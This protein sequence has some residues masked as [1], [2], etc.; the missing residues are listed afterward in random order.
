MDT[1]TKRIFCPKCESFLLEKLDTEL[2]YYCSTCEESYPANEWDI[3]DQDYITDERNITKQL[4]RIKLAPFCDCHVKVRKKCTECSKA[5]M[6]WT[7]L[8]S[9]MK[10]VFS[11]TC[12]N[13]QFN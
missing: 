1:N 9:N 5:I 11:C 7:P 8:G 2:S 13:I 3:I 12:G 10:S 6:A 4:T